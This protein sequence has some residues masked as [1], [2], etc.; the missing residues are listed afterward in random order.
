M[1]ELTIS[2]LKYEVFTIIA[3]RDYL[4]VKLKFMIFDLRVKVATVA[5]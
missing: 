2:E 4:K 3:P 5:D 1:I